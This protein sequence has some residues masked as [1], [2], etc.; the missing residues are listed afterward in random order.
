MARLQILKEIDKYWM[1]NIVS[2]PG[3]KDL[4]RNNF[5]QLPRKQQKPSLRT[6]RLELKHE[7]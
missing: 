7:F 3:Q 6:G 2:P 5:P 1:T 4:I